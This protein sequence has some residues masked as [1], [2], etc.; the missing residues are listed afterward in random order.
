MIIAP[1]NIECTFVK[2]GSA[3][4]HELAVFMTSEGEP[5]SPTI[6]CT[7]TEGRCRGWTGPSTGKRTTTFR[8]LCS[9]ITVYIRL[10]F[11]E[12]MLGH[13]EIHWVDVGAIA[14]IRVCQPCAGRWALGEC[15]PRT[16]YLRALPARLPRKFTNGVHRDRPYRCFVCQISQFGG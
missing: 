5:V 1:S 7:S 2:M 3:V 4:S 8:D 15:L 11:H 13:R 14:N 9:T 16:P 10:C 12:A 6:P